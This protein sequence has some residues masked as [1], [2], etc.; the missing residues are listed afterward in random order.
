MYF[1]IGEWLTSALAVSNGIPLPQQTSPAHGMTTDLRQLASAPVSASAHRVAPRR[2]G[3]GTNDTTFD[4]SRAP[5]TRA[6]V[7][8]ERLTDVRPVCLVGSRNDSENC[9]LDLTPGANVDVSASRLMLAGCEASL[10]PSVSTALTRSGRDARALEQAFSETFAAESQGKFSVP[11]IAQRIT[12]CLRQISP[13]MPHLL[14]HA[15]V[16]LEMPRV[17]FLHRLTS[18]QEARRHHVTT[19]FPNPPVGRITGAPEVREAMLGAYIRLPLGGGVHTFIVSLATPHTVERIREDPR[20]HAGQHLHAIFGD[21]PEYLQAARLQMRTVAP[22]D[23]VVHTLA[24]WLHDGHQRYRDFAR[25]ETRE[26]LAPESHRHVRQ[27]ACP[28]AAPPRTPDAARTPP[29]AQALMQAEVLPQT[30]AAPAPTRSRRDRQ[31][32]AAELAEALAALERL[33]KQYRMLGR[34]RFG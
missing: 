25:S 24:E 26:T 7:F 6:R 1:A 5:A 20:T 16:Y 13:G 23:D 3:A 28:P 32:S 2:P 21:V 17:T 4:W 33:D 14:R 31:P 9:L 12:E 22:G 11:A 30:G 19:P 27:P 10:P 29:R 34:P 8:A 15:E 18:E